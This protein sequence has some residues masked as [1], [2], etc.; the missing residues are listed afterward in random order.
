MVLLTF[1]GEPRTDTARDPHPV[2]WNVKG[3]LAVLGVLAAVVGVINLVPIEKLTGANID[4]LHDYLNAESANAAFVGFE[5]YEELLKAQAGIEPAYI[6]GEI[7]TLLGSA[8]LSL[9]LAVGGAA[10]AWS[11]YSGPEPERHTEKLGSI[12][13]LLFNNYYQDEYQVWLAQDVGVG[14]ARVADRFDN[15]V[16]DGTVNLV[17]SVSLFSGDRLR[18]IQTGIVSN[19][20]A[21][22]TLGLVLL[23]VTFGVT[24]GWF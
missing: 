13:D 10:L 7:V 15:G 17:S 19:Y 21:L 8:A 1:H 23:L 3:P 12:R 2:R 16:V 18:R 22:I 20:A 6:G 11:L 9:G 5:H 14:I 4:W 24:G